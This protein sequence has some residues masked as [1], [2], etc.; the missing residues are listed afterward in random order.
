MSGAGRIASPHNEAPHGRGGP[1]PLPV[2][3]LTEKAQ[4]ALASVGSAIGLTAIKFIAGFMTGSLGILAEA[5]HSLLDFFAAAVTWV[6]VKISGRPADDR[7][8]YGHGK[9]ENLSALVESLLLLATC[10]W[11]GFEAVERLTGAMPSPIPDSGWRIAIG[12]MVVSI[13]V[14]A[15]RARM[16]YRV[17]RKHRSQALEADALHFSSDILS[18]IVVIIGLIG[19]KL[20]WP[21]ADP[22]AALLVAAWVVVSAVRL[23]RDS[24]HGL[25]DTAPEKGNERVRDAVRLVPGV[26]DV[27]AVRLRQ[28]GPDMFADVTLQVDRR[29]TVARAHIVADAVEEA[30]RG[31]YPGAQVQVHEEPVSTAASLA[32]AGGPIREAFQSVAEEMQIP[33]HHLRLFEGPSGITAW[34]DVEFPATLSL[35]E[36][37]HRA[38]S[39]EREIARRVPQL[40]VVVAHIDIDYSD[41]DR[42]SGRELTPDASPLGELRDFICSVPGVVGCHALFLQEIPPR[43][44]AAHGEEADGAMLLSAHVEMPADLT[45]AQSHQIAVAVERAVCE[46]Y[47][48]VRRV[49]IHQQ[50]PSRSPH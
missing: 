38:D 17:A 19:V 22:I 9:I 24:I 44:D 10:G 15:Y 36:A 16:L 8:H 28:S 21:K 18:S 14:D 13:V 1:H 39:L 29:L 33:Y 30:V 48:Q 35:A 37:R 11:I 26:E 31:V 49:H 7:H 46:R 45:V 3:P 27:S 32:T 40:T 42:P 50:P 5:L 41:L 34:V 4:A 23:I 47:P 6:S 20:G 43:A 25:M 12:V 2:D